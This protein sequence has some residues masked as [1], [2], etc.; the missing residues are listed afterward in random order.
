MKTFFAEIETA[1][2]KYY[3]D[4]K[5]GDDYHHLKNKYA[6]MYSTGAVYLDSVQDCLNWIE[7]R[8]SNLMERV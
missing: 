7:F 6:V 4:L 3:I 1:C 5:S 8:D 2:G